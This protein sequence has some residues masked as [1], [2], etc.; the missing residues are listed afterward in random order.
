MRLLFNNSRKQNLRAY[1]RKT[2]RETRYEIAFDQ[3]YDP[4]GAGGDRPAGLVGRLRGGVRV[5]LR[6]R[7]QG[8]RSDRKPL[9]A[10]H[11]RE[12][13]DCRDQRRIPRSLCAIIH[14]GQVKIH[15]VE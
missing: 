6:L 5:L 4:R 15:P 7:Q 1:Y 13:G 2:H 8:R 14:Y 9:S 12:E 3:G 11:R 10:L